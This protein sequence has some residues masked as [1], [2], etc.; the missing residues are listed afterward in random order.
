[1]TDRVKPKKE[2]DDPILGV[3]KVIRYTSENTRPF[4][5]WGPREL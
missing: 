1:M 4:G 2:E 3:H 5:G